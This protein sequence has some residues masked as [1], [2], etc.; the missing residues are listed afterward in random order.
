MV[1][2][3]MSATRPSARS[4]AAATI[5]ALVA[6]AANSVLCRLALG[7]GAVDAA[8]FTS[9]RLASGALVLAALAWTFH[10]G[11]GFLRRGSWRGA[12]ALYGYAIAFSV[13]YLSLS[14][15]TGALILFGAVQ[16]TMVLQGLRAGER[17]GVRG[18]LG[19]VVASAGLVYLVL[20][21]VTAPAPPG[22]ACMAFAGACWGVYSL[23]GRGT[24][25]PLPDTAANFVRATPLALATS[26]VALS[27]LHLSPTGAALAVASG[28][29]SSGLGYVV[30]YAALRG[31]SATR[32]AVVQLTVPLLAALGGALFL[33]ERFTLRL[34]VAGLLILGGVALA[35]AERAAKSP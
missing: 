20:P 9:V 18:W 8:S 5:A 23:I 12:F 19:L 13:A 6:F 11:P 16:L 21:G 4:T 34:A 15:G 31:L 1:P 30:W 2:G 14:A 32:A 27:W 29:I 26:L 10:G 22:A 24:R 25:D 28:A 3:P 33:G 17:P 35:I 7:A